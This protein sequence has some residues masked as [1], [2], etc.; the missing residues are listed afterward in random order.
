MWKNIPSTEGYQASIDGQIRKAGNPPL[1]PQTNQSGY[2]VVSVKVNGKFVT[3]P[4]SRLVLEAFVGPPPTSDYEAAHNDGIRT[5][6]SLKNL[7]WDTRSG[8]QRDRLVHGTHLRGERAASA[9]FTNKQVKVMRSLLNS[10]KATRMELS[11]KHCVSYE[12]IRMMHA[13]RTYVDVK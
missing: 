2:Y 5:N 11:K 12:T 6:N 1:K 10:G 4:V 8:N 7:R 9:R 13:G 3:R